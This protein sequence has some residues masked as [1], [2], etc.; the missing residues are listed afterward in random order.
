M[1]TRRLLAAFLLLAPAAGCAD[2]N[3]PTPT[4]PTAAAASASTPEQAETA[5]LERQARR[6]ARALGDPAFRRDLQ[7]R[8]DASRV[9]EHK[10]H[11]QR[12]LKEDNGRVLAAIARAAGEDEAAVTG[13]ASS[14]LASELYFPV[15]GHRERWAGG[16][17]VLVATALRDHE[18]PVAFDTEGRR[19]V[20]SAATP[21]DLPVLALVPAE[22][23][24]ERLEGATEAI[25]TVDCGGGGGGTPTPAL[26]LTRAWFNGD[27]EGWLKGNPEFELHIMGP[28]SAADTINL[29]SYQCVGE[30]APSGY[31]WDMNSS[32]WSGSAQVF[33]VA[34]MDAFQQQYPGKAYLVFALEDDD[35]A[36]AIRTDEDRAATMLSAL[37]QAFKDFK[38]IKDTKVVTPDGV[39]RVIK[40]A[41]S[42]SDLL[43]A[44]YNFIKSNDD[45]IGFAVADSV[46]GRSSSIGHWVVLD[47]NLNANGWLNL[48]VK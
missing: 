5:R 31:T 2:R 18:A 6:L 21:P 15:P 30:H 39:V 17:N 32:N 48:E 8:L 35:G 41:Q 47:K 42:G 19:R 36:C 46:A 1:S 44:I 11:F 26:R 40:A 34:Q 14:G 7:S 16:P 24:F 37:S 25:C 4:E 12:L 9:A 3:T 38:A 23:D 20:L 33:T 13:D 27:Y 28:T 45:I 10:L 22:T 43:N 29:L